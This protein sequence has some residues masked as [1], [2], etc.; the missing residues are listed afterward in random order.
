MRARHVGK[1]TKAREGVS[2]EAKLAKE[3]KRKWE[4]GTNEK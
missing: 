3:S 1:G 2:K 4:D